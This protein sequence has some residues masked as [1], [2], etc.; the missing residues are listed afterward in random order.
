MPAPELL[1]GFA[2]LMGLTAY[3]LLGG[4]DFGGGVWDLFASGV[5]RERQIGRASCRERVYGPV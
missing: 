3:L 2:L 1:L 5:R 4:A